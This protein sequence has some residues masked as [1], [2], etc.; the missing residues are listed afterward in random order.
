M[1]R[2]EY[3]VA[4]AHDAASALSAGA[5]GE[6]S[7]DPVAL[8]SIQI[9]TTCRYLL[10]AGPGL[11]QVEVT[12][13]AEVVEDVEDVEVVDDPGVVWRTAGDDVGSA[14]EPMA[15]V[16]SVTD[17]DVDGAAD[18][19]TVERPCGRS[20]PPHAGRVATTHRP[21]SSRPGRIICVVCQHEEG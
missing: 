21:T 2:S 11:P 12:G 17:V 5:R 19:T 15:V 7:T 16:R 13:G 6:P 4:E 9:H 14:P 8:F 18:G 10:G 3:R 1:P 20:L